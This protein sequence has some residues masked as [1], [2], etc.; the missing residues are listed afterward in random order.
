[1]NELAKYVHRNHY[2]RRTGP[3]QPSMS[4]LGTSTPD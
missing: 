3:R 1:L 4:L 2:E